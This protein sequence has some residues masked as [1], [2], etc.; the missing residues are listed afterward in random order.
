[1]PAY[2]VAVDDPTLPKGALVEVPPVGLVENQGDGV[3]VELDKEQAELMR[4]N[5]V[6]KIKQ[7]KKSD[8]EEGGDTK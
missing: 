4:A 7:G 6:I 3:T 5:S 1:M 2:E 8:I